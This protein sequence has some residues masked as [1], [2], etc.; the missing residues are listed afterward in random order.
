MTDQAHD[1]TDKQ[2]A[3]LSDTIREV[4]EQAASE[5]EAKLGDWLKDYDKKREEWERRVKSGSATQEE[6]QEWLDGQATYKAWQQAMVDTLANDAVHADELC[7]QLINGEI[8]SIVAENANF[9][10]YDVDSKIGYDTGFTLYD[11]DTVMGL[12]KDNPDLLPV[13]GIDK[14][15]DTA[16]NKKKFSSAVTQG[17]LQG[18]SVP[19][20]AKRLR[21][22]FDMDTRASI[23]AARTAFTSAEN[24]GRITSYQRAQKLGIG[25]KQQW[26]A[27][28]DLRTRHTHRLLDGQTVDIGGY[29]EPDG[30]GEDYRVRFPADPLG[31][32][33]MVWNCRCRVVGAVE[34][35]DMSDA[36]R[37]S[38]L[39][40]GMTYDEWKDSKKAPSKDD[41]RKIIPTPWQSSQPKPQPKPQPK[42]YTSSK[43]GLWSQLG[44]HNPDTVRGKV[45]SILAGAKGNAAELWKKFEDKMTY[46]DPVHKK[47]N[48][49]VRGAYFSPATWVTSGDDQFGVHMNLT[50]TLHDKEGAL[51]TWFHEFGHHIDFS[52]RRGSWYATGDNGWEFGQTVKAEVEEYIKSIHDNANDKLKELRKK[53]DLK[54]ILDMGYTHGWANRYG[55]YYETALQNVDNDSWLSSHNMQHVTR[56]HG[57]DAREKA[58]F[59]YY[60]NLARV[61]SGRIGI[62]QV[63]DKVASDITKGGL[64]VQLAVSD[65]F[66]GATRGRCQDT[67]GHGRSYWAADCSNLAKEAFAEFFSAECIYGENNEILDTMAS[68]LPKSYA[69]YQKIVEG[70]LK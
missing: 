39:P 22:V 48:G 29:F 15:K 18:E 28:L 27:T 4:Y 47:R 59:E 43:S 12:I 40:D 69:A 45:E 34:G 68:M 30:Y 26:L 66:E 14:D 49:R 41:K 9:G 58:I 10:A 20:L 7:R 21:T 8:P 33:A 50:K 60:A 63:R 65:I 64:N 38:R 51:A 57:R 19:N 56:I 70:L 46:A 16:W 31:L 54:G 62:Q 44:Q 3:I 11:R 6:Y 17:V 37:W 55:D 1:W 25:L 61:P 2:I 42:T 24:A 5:M 36:E 32:P 53:R 52:S 67:Y 35:V 13:Q 23:R